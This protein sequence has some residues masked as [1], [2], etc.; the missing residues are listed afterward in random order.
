ML[1]RRYLH[2]LDSIEA[3]DLRVAH[4]YDETCSM[5]KCNTRAQ[6]QLVTK[7]TLPGTGESE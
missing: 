6:N 1:A 5:E 3:L 7:H 4:T 2:D